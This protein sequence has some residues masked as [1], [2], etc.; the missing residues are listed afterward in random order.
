MY[1]DKEY[2]VI[3]LLRFFQLGYF[4]L[5]FRQVEGNEAYK[6]FLVPVFSW[7]VTIW[8]FKDQSGR[9]GAIFSKSLETVPILYEV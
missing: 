4:F 8:M 3:D 7:A 9:T 5:Q 1:K 6:I 2:G